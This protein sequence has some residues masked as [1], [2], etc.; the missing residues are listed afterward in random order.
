MVTE[1]PSRDLEVATVIR[2]Q[3]G[4]R[5]HTMIGSS[6]FLCGNEDGLSFLQFSFKGSKRANLLRIILMPEDVYR[7]HF[8]KVWNGTV[9]EIVVRGMV[10]VEDLHDVIES[11]TGLYLSLGAGR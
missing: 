5:A 6:N 9:K 10:Y 11:E 2:Q 1:Q 4:H 8:S 3:L 7:L